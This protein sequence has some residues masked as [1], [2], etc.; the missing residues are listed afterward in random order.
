MLPLIVD[1]AV[2]AMSDTQGR[3]FYFSTG[4][5]SHTEIRSIDIEPFD[6]AITW[7]AAAFSQERLQLDSLESDSGE[8]FIPLPAGN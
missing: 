7:Y 3:L 6:D 8:V 2:D 4:Q 1:G 5:S